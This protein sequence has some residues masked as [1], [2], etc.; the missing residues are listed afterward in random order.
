MVPL[1]LTEWLTE[2]G[3]GGVTRCPAMMSSIGA[4]C[5]IQACHSFISRCV[6]LQEQVY[7]RV[8][9]TPYHKSK[10]LPLVNEAKN[11]RLVT[12]TG[13]SPRLSKSRL[14][15]SSSFWK[16]SVHLSNSLTQHTFILTRTLWWAHTPWKILKPFTLARYASLLLLA[17]FYKVKHSRE[18]GKKHLVVISFPFFSPFFLILLHSISKSK[19]KQESFT[20]LLYSETVTLHHTKSL[21]LDVCQTPKISHKS[22]VGIADTHHTQ[23]S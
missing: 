13:G 8:L 22:H 4:L 17:H 5:G 12:Q 7:V 6:F 3:K 2:H 15:C 9:I 20:E 10:G 16:A 11:S 14:C 1:M 19:N 18:E 21:A 23:G